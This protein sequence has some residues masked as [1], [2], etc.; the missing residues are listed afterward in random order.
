[1]RSFEFFQLQ[2]RDCTNHEYLIYIHSIVACFVDG[3]WDIVTGTFDAC[4]Y[5]LSSPTGDYDSAL[6]ECQSQTLSSN[7]RL[8]VINNQDMLTELNRIIA[9]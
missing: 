4:W 5:F 3:S 1:M 2:V 6:S 9:Q 8:A 7:A